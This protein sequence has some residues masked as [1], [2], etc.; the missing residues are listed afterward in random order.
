MREYTD[1]EI[2][3]I[4]Q[5]YDRIIQ[6]LRYGVEAF[7]RELV[8]LDSNDDWLCS[9]L[10]LQHSGNG[11]EE[12]TVTA[13]YTLAVARG[14]RHED[15]QQDADFFRCVAFGKNAEFAEKYLHKGTKIA[16]SGHLHSGSYTNKDG[17]KVYNMNIVVEQHEFAES[18]RDQTSGGNAGEIDMDTEFLDI[19]KMSEEELPFR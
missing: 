3:Q 18:K 13:S 10:A 1:Q 17:V 5:D 2:C 4:I 8:S 11:E 15:G 19:S 14:Y 6:E 12:S 16:I 7:V 9:L